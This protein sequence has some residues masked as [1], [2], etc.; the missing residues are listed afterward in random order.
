MPDYDADALSKSLVYALTIVGGV[1]LPIV[2]VMHP[3]YFR[4]RKARR[5][6]LRSCLAS[7]AICGLFLGV[8]LGDNGMPPQARIVPLFGLYGLPVVLGMLYLSPRACIAFVGAWA[9]TV[10]FGLAFV[11]YVLIC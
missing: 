4:E 6:T 5:F 8:L 9:L 1:T 3:H 11:L 7:I 2:L 10:T